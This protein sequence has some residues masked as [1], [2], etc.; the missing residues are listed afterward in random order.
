MNPKSDASALNIQEINN[1][2]NTMYINNVLI[3][4]GYC[5]E[6]LYSL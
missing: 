1:Y 3:T 2:V 6:V 5:G 4:P